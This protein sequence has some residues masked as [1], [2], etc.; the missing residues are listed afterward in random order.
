PRHPPHLP[1]FPTRR[2]S[3]LTSLE[4]VL[5]VHSAHAARRAAVAVLLLLRSLRNHDLGREQQSRHRGGVLQR[6][7]RHLGRIEDALFEQ[8]P[9]RK[10]SRLNS[11]HQI[12]SYA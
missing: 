3:D 6:Q 11:S 2:S 4:G 12:I 9:D 8:I 10:S 7:A 1:P 5:H